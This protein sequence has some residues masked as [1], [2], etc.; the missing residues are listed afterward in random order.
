MKNPIF[1]ILALL[2]AV[3]GFSGTAMAK[4]GKKNRVQ[5]LVDYLDTLG[6][7][8]SKADRGGTKE[9]VG[10]A[11]IY[12][13]EG[14]DFSPKK[15]NELEAAIRANPAPL[16]EI[17]KQKMI[18][19]G[20]K[21]KRLLTVMSALGFDDPSHETRAKLC[22]TYG[23]IKTV[24]QYK[25]KGNATQN[26]ALLKKLVEAHEKKIAAQNAKP[27][28]SA[29]NTKLPEAEKPVD[30][31]APAPAPTVQA[32]PNP[33]DVKFAGAAEEPPLPERAETLSHAAAKATPSLFGDSTTSGASSSPASSNPVT[34][35]T[36]APK[37]AKSEVK[38][39]AQEP[40]PAESFTDEKNEA[41]SEGWN[42]GEFFSKIFT[43]IGSF[44]MAVVMFPIHHWVMTLF[45][46]VIALIAW[47]LLNQK[48]FTPPAAKVAA[49]SP[50]LKVVNDPRLTSS[51]ISKPESKKEGL[52]SDS[53]M[54]LNLYL[55]TGQDNVLN[56]LNGRPTPEQLLYLQ[57]HLPGSEHAAKV[58][59][60]IERHRAKMS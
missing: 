16:L 44:V 30:P 48:K 53:I 9:K 24:D 36:P 46:L 25:R 56:A 47:N 7:P 34:S 13:I 20:V 11:Q 59:A 39:T 27:A 4:G 41:L 50:K 5:G 15:N 54:T 49:P 40:P 35:P 1:R 2:I 22:V 18:S 6:V 38:E 3:F 51:L 29:E 14:Y 8:S 10:Y 21:K 58:R 42:I 19:V 31:V 37:V 17:K 60:Y 32:T 28:P 23:V 43:P 55:M 26:V 52:D 45:V 12:K 33:T 57:E